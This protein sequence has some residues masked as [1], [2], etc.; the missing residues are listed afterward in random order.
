[1]A[2]ESNRRWIESTRVVDAV[3]AFLDNREVQVE[4]GPPGRRTWTEAA[5][6]EIVEGRPM[7]IEMEPMYG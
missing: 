5:P 6:V 7:R 2:G 3:V 1:M 4:V